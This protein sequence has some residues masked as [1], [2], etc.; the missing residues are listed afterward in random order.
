MP[1][2]KRNDKTYNVSD[3]HRLAMLDIFVREIDDERLM[4]DDHFVKNWE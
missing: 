1:S 2:G 3:D 4:I